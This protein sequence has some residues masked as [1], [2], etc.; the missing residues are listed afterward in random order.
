MVTYG[1][2]STRPTTQCAFLPPL[3]V[4]ISTISPAW[5]NQ[6]AKTL[7]NSFGPS[8]MSTLKDLAK[9]IVTIGHIG[10]VTLDGRLLEAR[11]DVFDPFCLQVKVMGAEELPRGSQA[12]HIQPICQAH[13]QRLK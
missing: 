1:P 5:E 10:H 13:A 9:N 2:M 4:L 6:D 11:L 3:S 12:A 7:R 8:Y